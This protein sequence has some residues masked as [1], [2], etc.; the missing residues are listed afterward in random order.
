MLCR[1]VIRSV[2]ENFQ[3][4]C[5]SLYNYV[6]NNNNVT[7]YGVYGLAALLHIGGCKKHISVLWLV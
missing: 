7:G 1:N 2:R 5:T 3:H 6:K 4:N